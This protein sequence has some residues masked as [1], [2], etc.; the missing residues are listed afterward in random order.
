[1]ARTFFRNALRLSK[2]DIMRQPSIDVYE[3]T[4]AVDTVKNLPIPSGASIAIINSELPIYVNP[5]N[6]AVIPDSTDFTQSTGTE[7]S[8]S[9]Y[10]VTDV[11]QL[12]F[13][14][15]TDANNVTVSFYR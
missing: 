8:P 4:L 2:T 14:S 1:M 15:P 7:L 13:I 12:S 5:L 9:I 3:C 11:E 6:T 10:D